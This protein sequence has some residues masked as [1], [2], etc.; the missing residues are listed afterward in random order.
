MTSPTR[1]PRPPGTPRRPA[2]VGA[3]DDRSVGLLLALDRRDGDGAV[4]DGLSRAIERVVRYRIPGE[5]SDQL[6]LAAGTVVAG[7]RD[8]RRSVVEAQQVADAAAHLPRVGGF[9]RL[10]DVGVRGLLSLLRDD[11]RV[12]TFTERELG[13][14]L[15]REDDLLEV[16]R[17]YLASGRNKSA[18]AA[19]DA[20]VPA[21]RST[22]GSPGWRPCWTRTWTTSRPA[23]P[24]TSPCWPATPADPAA[25]RRPSGQGRSAK[26]RPPLTSHANENAKVAMVSHQNSRCTDDLSSTKATSIDSATTTPQTR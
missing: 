5:A 6:L 19:A 9:V 17:A 20:P 21:R 11:P 22:T 25:R 24:C 10:H 18:A 3:I 15:D 8:A 1:W 7:L 2:L 16:L 14:L 23:S 26:K 13:P 12:E 4:L